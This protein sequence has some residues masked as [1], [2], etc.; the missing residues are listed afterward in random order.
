MIKLKDKISRIHKKRMK[1][2]KNPDLNREDL[3]RGSTKQLVE[4]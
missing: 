3:M 2:Q 1:K 4:K